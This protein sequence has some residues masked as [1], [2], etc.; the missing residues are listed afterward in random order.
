MCNQRIFLLFAIYRN[1]DNWMVTINLQYYLLEN[2]IFSIH[3][4][5]FV[6]SFFSIL[7]CVMSLLN[8]DELAHNLDLTHAS[9]VT[10]VSLL[11]G[12]I[13][14]ELLSTIFV[15]YAAA[16][17]SRIWLIPYLFEKIVQLTFYTILWFTLAFLWFSQPII[18]GVAI[19]TLL[20][21]GLY[22]GEK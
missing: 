11:L 19:F 17:N 20:F 22:L 15:I 13:S 16:Y 21:G 6:S 9:T 8:I 7:G 12:F 4:I 10:N 14:I 5:G 1:C 2:S 3:R 18:I